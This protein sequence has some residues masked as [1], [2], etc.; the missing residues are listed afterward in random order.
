MTP[1]ELRWIANRAAAIEDLDELPYSDE[2]EA[3]YTQFCDAFDESTTRHDFWMAVLA[4]RSKPK[5]N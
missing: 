1:D 5:W 3:L 4:S 2:F